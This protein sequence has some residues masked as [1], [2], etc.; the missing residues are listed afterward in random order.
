MMGP[1][2]SQ[3]IAEGLLMIGVF[4]FAAGVAVACLLIFG[5]PWLWSLL[6]PWLHA[7]TG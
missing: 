4:L 1:G 3:G 5:V 6:K 2:F 7:I